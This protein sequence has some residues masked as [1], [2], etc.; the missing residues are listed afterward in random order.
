MSI[1]IYAD[2]ADLAQMFE[3]AQD[4]GISGFTTNPSLMKKSGV[5]DYE[6]F[7][8]EA[9]SVITKPI[10]FEVFADD[11]NEMERQA[12]LISSWGEN[13]YVKIPIT[14]TRGESSIPLIERLSKDGVKVNVT[15]VFTVAQVIDVAKVLIGPAILSIFCGRIADTGRNP[16]TFCH[17]A[18]T[19]CGTNV[20]VLWAST[21]ELLNI[22][23]AEECGCDI[24]TVP[25]D[26]LKKMNLIGKDLTEYSLETVKMFRDDAKA[27]GFS[28]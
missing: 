20:E 24:I 14:N 21:R 15:A 8:K 4:P 9:L 6:G 11:F 12:R 16:S 5:T 28:L 27:S 1:K 17:L 13:V 3:Q 19:F 26:L 2:G 25:N 18:A 23:Q 22:K 7:A 10:S